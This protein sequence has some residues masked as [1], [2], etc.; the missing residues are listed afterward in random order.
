ML[1]RDAVECPMPPRHGLFS[2]DDHGWLSL[3]NDVAIS[4][5]VELEPEGTAMMFLRYAWI[6]A[7]AVLR[8]K[9]RPFDGD[10]RPFWEK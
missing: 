7:H 2:P 10:A 6:A 3:V 9:Q 8:A 4:T 5:E 1:D